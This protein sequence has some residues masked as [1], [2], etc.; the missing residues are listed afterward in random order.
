M[1]FKRKTP[2]KGDVAGND[3]RGRSTVPSSGN[4][5]KTGQG[6][7]DLEK[8]FRSFF[9]DCKDNKLVKI[10]NL[11]ETERNKVNSRLSASLL[12]EKAIRQIHTKQIAESFMKSEH[13]DA[14]QYFININYIRET[15]EELKHYFKIFFGSSIEDGL[16]IIYQLCDQ[17]HY[18]ETKK[19][20]MISFFDIDLRNALSHQDYEFV[21]KGEQ[22]MHVI[23]YTKPRKIW[24][25]KDLS[26]QLDKIRELNFIIG[27]VMDEYRA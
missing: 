25:M 6:I 20:Q 19:L 2:E 3:E 14:L 24:N 5:F 15:T 10:T 21:M 12:R 18:E 26:G 4:D 11:D 1:T 22:I 17:L 8:T 9:E 13:Y 27:R 23:I 7:T 16:K